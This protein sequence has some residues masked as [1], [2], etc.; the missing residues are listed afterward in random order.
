M[1]WVGLYKQFGYIYH[2]EYTSL[3]ADTEQTIVLKKMQKFAVSEICLI[4]HVW[5]AA[6]WDELH[7]E[8]K[9]QKCIQKT[10]RFLI[11]I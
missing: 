3:Y 4:K 9:I 2:P 7:T 1:L 5:T 10:K 6:P 8:M 11:D